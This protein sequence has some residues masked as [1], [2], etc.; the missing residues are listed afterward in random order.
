MSNTLDKLGVDRSG[1]DILCMC[2]KLGFSWKKKMPPKCCARIDIETGS[3]SSLVQLN[4]ISAN[5]RSFRSFWIGTS[6]KGCIQIPFFQELFRTFTVL[7]EEWV[8]LEFRLARGMVLWV[9]VCVYASVCA[10]GLLSLGSTSAPS[11]AL[12]SCLSLRSRAFCYFFTGWHKLFLSRSFSRV[13]V[14]IRSWR[15]RFKCTFFLRQIC[16]ILSI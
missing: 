3:D 9:W 5:L 2:S 11:F 10:S 6:F 16:L 1:G 13:R 4:V 14:L 15:F 8:I 7:I 12:S